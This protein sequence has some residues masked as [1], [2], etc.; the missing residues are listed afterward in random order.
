MKSSGIRRVNSDG[1]VPRVENER[2]GEQ[3]CVY[4]MCECVML[5]IRKTEILF[6]GRRRRDTLVAGDRG[7]EN[8]QGGATGS[9]A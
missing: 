5:N 8:E 6:G 9:G 4:V 2:M 1:I 7:T 3:E